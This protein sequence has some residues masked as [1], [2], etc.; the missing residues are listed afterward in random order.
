MATTPVGGGPGS[1]RVALA[2]A[3]GVLMAATSAR[4]DPLLEEP[5]AP[6]LLEL[7]L[8]LLLLVAAAASEVWAAPIEAA[9]AVRRRPTS[10]AGLCR[11][12]RRATAVDQR[13]CRA[14]FLVGGRNTSSGPTAW[15][16]WRLFLASLA[17]STAHKAKTQS[18][19]HT[20]GCR[21]ALDASMQD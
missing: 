2:S 5:L 15:A 18:D 12:A 19:S 9:A 11:V 4:L 17:A 7:G 21:L 8:L 16:C 14:T 20:V 1:K 3:T 10:F 13:C 6:L